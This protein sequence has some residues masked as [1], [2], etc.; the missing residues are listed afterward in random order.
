MP[1]GPG[2]GASQNGA[3]QVVYAIRTGRRWLSVP[4]PH[5][6]RAGLDPV[7]RKAFHDQDVRNA[8]KVC[9][10]D[11]LSW[12]ISSAER[13]PIGQTVRIKKVPFT[14]IGVLTAKASRHGQDQDDTI[15]I[16]L[17]TAQK[18]I[19]G[20]SFVGMVRAI[21]VKAKSAGDLAAAEEQI[22][23]LLKQRHRI[24]P[25]QDTD[26]TVRKSNQMMQAA[27]QSTQVMGLLLAAIASVSL[28]VGG[29]GS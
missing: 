26:F 28:L 5:L 11:K 23:A 15:F 4:H 10:W 16:P 13:I 17:T 29:I 18:K 12:T 3:A 19:F 21:T 27:E 25:R 8:T 22:D 9:L 2:S 1:G 20:V 7:G 24:S 6:D 14:V